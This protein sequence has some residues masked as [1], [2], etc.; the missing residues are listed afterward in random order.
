MR[1]E[2][3]GRRDRTWGAER[4]GDGTVD[5]FGKEDEIRE[6]RVG[7]L[8]LLDGG[9]R[10]LDGGLMEMVVRWWVDGGGGLMMG[11]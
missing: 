10:W 11:G 1:E 6:G 8:L 2:M 9:R 7:L 5:V 3:P 4:V